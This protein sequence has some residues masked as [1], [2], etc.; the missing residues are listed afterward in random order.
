LFQTGVGRFSEAG[1]KIDQVNLSI[2]EV[3]LRQK[4]LK[5]GCS[6]PGTFEQWIG[7]GSL[8]STDGTGTG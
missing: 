6:P 2:D 3:D 8:I 5:M 4:Y 1:S 7:T